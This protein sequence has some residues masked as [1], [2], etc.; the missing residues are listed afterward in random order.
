[1]ITINPENINKL[2]TF[3]GTVL[4]MTI[5]ESY[6]NVYNF[7]LECEASFTKVKNE[8]I[9]HYPN[10][11]WSRFNFYTTATDAG[12]FGLGVCITVL[13]KNSSEQATRPEDGSL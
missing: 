13:S 8:I 7:H 12:P 4:K 11:L 10:P 3:L 9:K 2:R 5:T 6:Q 1:M